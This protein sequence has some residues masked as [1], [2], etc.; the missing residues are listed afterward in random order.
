MMRLSKWHW[1]SARAGLL[2]TRKFKAP[3]YAAVHFLRGI[4]VGRTSG[5]SMTHAT[6]LRQ[7]A[8]GRAAIGA[9]ALGALAVGAF[10]LGAFA[11]GGL[12]VGRMAVGK[13][14]LKAVSIDDLTI[15][16]LQVR[17]LT[18]TDSLRTPG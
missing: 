1:V 14:N 13:A 4:L 15:E 3:G 10:A 11:I 6:N 18:V 7:F 17:E 16:R 2:Q 5:N 9:N 8:I 12:V